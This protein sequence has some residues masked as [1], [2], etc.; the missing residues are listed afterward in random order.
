MYDASIQLLQ[1]MWGLFENEL[2]HT[3]VTVP[4]EGS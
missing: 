4:D 2:P 3:S 1:K